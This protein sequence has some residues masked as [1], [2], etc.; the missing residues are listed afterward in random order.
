MMVALVISRYPLVPPIGVPTPAAPLPPPVP[1]PAPPVLPVGVVPEVVGVVAGVLL[2]A[3]VVGCVVAGV[4]DCCVLVVAG[5]DVV[6]GLVAL[7]VGV[8][9]AGVLVVW[10]QSFCASSATVE[11]PWIRL[12]RSVALTVGGRPLTE[13]FSAVAALAAPAQLPAAS[14][15]ETWL[16]WPES[17]LD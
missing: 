8:V 2:V 6:V 12:L 14:A 5:V 9:A 16:S 1:R 17:V 4:V 13:L 15:E 10:W 3:G 7:V 11:A